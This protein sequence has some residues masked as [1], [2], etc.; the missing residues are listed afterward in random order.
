MELLTHL[1]VGVLVEG[2]A[3]QIG[4]TVS[5]TVGQKLNLKTSNDINRDWYG[6]G[7]CWIVSNTNCSDIFALEVM[8]VGQLVYPALIPALIAALLQV[9]LSFLRFKNFKCLFPMH[10]LFIL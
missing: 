1:F 10:L 2:V 6:S 9:R 3:V 8:F 5:H 4:A 7:V